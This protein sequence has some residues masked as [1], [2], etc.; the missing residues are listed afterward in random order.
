MNIRQA[1]NS[2]R[3]QW[4]N[5]VNNNPDSTPYHL[6]AWTMAIQ[7][8]YG[9]KCINLIAEEN[10]RILGICPI[11][12]LKIPFKQPEMVALPYCDVGTILS[13]DKES[14]A[15][16]INELFSQA[17]STDSSII[18]IRGGIDRDLLESHGYPVRSGSNKVRML[19]DLPGSS[20]E[21]WQGFKSKLRSQV[22][23][24]EK[25][26]L[27]FLFTNEKTD[28]FY[29]VF[30]RNMRDLGSPVHSTKWF[31]EIIKNYGDDAKMGLVYHE[32]KAIG[33]GIILR[34]GNTISIPWASTLRQYNRLGPNMLLYWNFLRFAADN[35]CSSFD[36]GRSTPNQ[37]TY[38]FKTQWGA[39]PVALQ[40]H[41]IYLDGVLPAQ[42]ETSKNRERIADIWQ[43]L[44]LV[45][46][47]SI[48]PILRKYI[49]L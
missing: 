29:S 4:D 49:S 45:L 10:N 33:A 19:M 25:N 40:W 24:A 9:F 36:F 30:S 23:K 6:S 44:P 3:E 12:I 37:G 5:Y 48:G 16:L 39:K 20:D 27:T 28:Q 14:Q 17:K 22:R 26:G 15:E 1:S 42:K 2:D 31:E 21:L 18:D 47:N 46:A 41:T 32:K 8:A 13:T 34:A 35:G 7:R 43:K 11:T 38:R